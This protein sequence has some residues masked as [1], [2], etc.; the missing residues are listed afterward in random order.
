MSMCPSDSEDVILREIRRTLLA[1]RLLLH[2]VR[3]QFITRLTDLT[4]DRQRT[5]RKRLMISGKTRLRGHPRDALTLFLSTSLARAEAAAIAALLWLFEIPIEP[6]TPSI[7][8]RVSF[9]FGERLCD[10]YEAYCACYPRTRV[11]LDEIIELRKRLAR[12]DRMQ[13]GRC[14]DCKCLLLIDRNDASLECLHC[15]AL[16]G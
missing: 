10:T 2:G 5:L 4:E 16:P 7:P 3:T 6:T 9:P 15:G 11:T 13:L 1:R 14:S 12:G 8:K